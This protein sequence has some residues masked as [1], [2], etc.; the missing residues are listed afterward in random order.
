VIA[1]EE[2]GLADVAEHQVSGYLAPYGDPAGI[3]AG[4]Q[5]VLAD[6][7]RLAQLSAAARE[8]ALMRFAF[9]RVAASYRELYAA[10]LDRRGAH[11]A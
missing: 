8:R 6:D 3:A 4:I 11:P 10:I 5:W 7:T 2:T 9:A 1:F